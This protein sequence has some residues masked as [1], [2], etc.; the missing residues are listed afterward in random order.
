MMSMVVVVV[1]RI[2]FQHNNGEKMIVE[3]VVCR[4][5]ILGGTVECSMHGGMIVKDGS[6]SIMPVRPHHSFLPNALM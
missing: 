2:N 1:V 4:N 6:H 3:Y 5:E